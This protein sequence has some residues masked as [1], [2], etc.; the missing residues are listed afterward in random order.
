[1]KISRYI[2]LAILLLIPISI[3]PILKLAV[4]DISANVEPVDLG[5]YPTQEDFD[6]AREKMA[7]IGLDNALEAASSKL[8]SPDNTR[9]IN[10]TFTSEELTALFSPEES[11]TLPF[12]DAQI[13][14]HSHSIVEVSGILLADRMPTFASH[15][16]IPAGKAIQAMGYL[17]L[18]RD[19]PFYIKGNVSISKQQFKLDITDLKIGKIFMSS[20]EI[21]MVQ[22]IITPYIE[23]ELNNNKQGVSISSMAINN[24]VVQIEGIFP[25]QSSN[26]TH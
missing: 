4:P 12:S 6:Q 22:N 8:L 16:G 11:Q 1:M 25:I 15:M 7:G 20:D 17:N 13:K 19:M 26:C 5:V 2:L 14:L 9:S 10:T 21:T 18:T 3:Y 23:R 24:D